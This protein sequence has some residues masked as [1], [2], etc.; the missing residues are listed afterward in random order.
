MFF[1]IHL[2]RRGNSYNE[3]AGILAK[4]MYICVECSKD[5]FMIHLNYMYFIKIV[6]CEEDHYNERD[7]REKREK[8]R[9]WRIKNCANC[10]CVKCPCLVDRRL[11]YMYY[12]A[13]KIH[14]WFNK[15]DMVFGMWYGQI[16]RENSFFAVFQ[17]IRKKKNNIINVACVEMKHVLNTTTD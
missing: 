1:I 12:A 15:S 13:R 6:Y 9:H 4:L 5:A 16:W 8:K 11:F 2:F 7:K 3:T 17:W 10:E 14:V